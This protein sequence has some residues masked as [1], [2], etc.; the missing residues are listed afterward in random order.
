[1]KT[2]TPIR[3]A[4]RLGRPARAGAAADVV[5]SLRLTAAER[6]RYKRAA[7]RNGVALAVWAR[8]TL[9]RAAARSER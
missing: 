6:D 8:N 7:K 1:M 2:G 4:V 5:L 3:E 9:D